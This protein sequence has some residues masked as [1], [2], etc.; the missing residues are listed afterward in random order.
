MALKELYEQIC[1]GQDL[2]ANLIELK[3]QLRETEKQNHFREI[4]GENYDRIMKCLAD[5]DPKVRKNAA[6]VLGVLRV[7]GAVDVLMDAWEAEE[8]L[9]VRA[10]YILALAGLD[11]ESYMKAFHRRL[12]ALRVYDAPENEKKHIQAEIAALQEL[13]LIKE[14]LKKHVF[15]GYHRPN[16]VILTT[17]PAFRE[18]LAADLPFQKTTLK[19]GVRT[20]VSD[21]S[22]VQTS[23]LWQEMLFVLNGGSHL[24]TRQDLSV[25]PNGHE[26]VRNREHFPMRPELLAGELK[27]SDLLTILVENHKGEPPFFFRI[28]LTGAIPKEER[29]G[30]TKKI[31]EAVERAFDGRLVNSVSHYEAEIRLNVNREGGVTPFLKLFT[32][33]D[34]RFSYRRF[35]VASS[36][37]PQTAAGILALAK[38]YLKEYAQVLDPF[39]GVGT[40]LLERRFAGSV[41]SAYGIDIYGE[42]IQKARANTKLTGMPVNYINR[43]FFDFTHEY[44]FDEI[45]TDMPAVSGD[46]EQTDELYR[47][48]FEKTAGLLT[49]RGRVFCYSR[50]MGLVKKHL[51]LSGRFRLLAEFCILEKSGAYLFILEKK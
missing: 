28:G 43:D 7:Q 14:G 1:A 10:D 31:A 34:H 16:D 25:T 41:R 13:I 19:S 47:R 22:I 44:S 39:C 30:I 40:L 51:R 27:K 2:R 18:A 32:L 20:T 24:S 12:E 15:S 49:E 36:M 48:F 8:T 46:R 9:F 11:C 35:Y 4:S 38:P 42:A 33:P 21:M 17:L 5:D 6:A 3:K 37:R 23:R 50:E 29:S 45:L 26:F